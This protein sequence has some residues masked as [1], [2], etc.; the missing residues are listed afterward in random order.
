MS[1]FLCNIYCIRIV[2]CKLSIV[3]IILCTKNQKK[4]LNSAVKTNKYLSLVIQYPEESL[5][6]VYTRKH[7]HSHQLSH[8]H[9]TTLHKFSLKIFFLCENITNC[10][11]FAI[12]PKDS[13]RQSLPSFFVKCLTILNLALGTN[14]GVI[15]RKYKENLNKLVER[16]LL[17]SI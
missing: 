16:H 9:N 11:I 5:S 1:R 4:F 7:C 13:D 10:A 6:P 8:H 3:K 17:E 15:F 14:S 2:L 12:N